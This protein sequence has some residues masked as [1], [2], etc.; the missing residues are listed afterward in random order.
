MASF[1]DFIEMQCKELEPA[2]NADDG[3]R[4]LAS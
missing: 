4:T 2:K 1:W 3:M